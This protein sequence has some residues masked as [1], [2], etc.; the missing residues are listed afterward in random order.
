[1]EFSQNPSQRFNNASSNLILLYQ[2]DQSKVRRQLQHFNSVLHR[3]TQSIQ[4]ISAIL[5]CN[6]QYIQID[7]FAQAAIEPYFPFAKVPALCKCRKIEETQ[8]NR[9]FDYDSGLE[10]LNEENRERYK[11]TGPRDAKK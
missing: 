10:G 5:K 11:N 6:R 4:L 7:T 8:V 3:F 1:M 9:L 2:I